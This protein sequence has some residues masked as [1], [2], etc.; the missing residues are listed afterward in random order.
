MGLERGVGASYQDSYPVG[1]QKDLV[2]VTFLSLG[3]K[4]QTPPKYRSWPTAQCRAAHRAE[5][6]GGES[7]SHEGGS[8]EPECKGVEGHS[9]RGPASNRE[10]ALAPQVGAPSLPPS[11]LKLQVPGRAQVT[12]APAAGA[13]FQFNF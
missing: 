1:A 2:L 13:S 5:D 8:S 12:A 4:Y 3:Q 11:A 7:C 6:P 10:S 9:P